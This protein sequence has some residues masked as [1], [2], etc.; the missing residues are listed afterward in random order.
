[1][2]IKYRTIGEYINQML[3]KARIVSLTLEEKPDQQNA[4]LETNIFTNLGSVGL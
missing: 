1:M 4:T 3:H 2:Q